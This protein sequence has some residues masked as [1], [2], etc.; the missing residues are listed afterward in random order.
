MLAQATSTETWVNAA[1][2][3]HVTNLDHFA[4]ASNATVYK[5][6]AAQLIRET[7]GIEPRDLTFVIH[8]ARYGDDGTIAKQNWYIYHSGLWTDA[9]FSSQRRI[10]GRKQIWLL[11][12]QF[13]ARPNSNTTYV[14]ETKKKSAAAFDH[15][16]QVMSLFGVNLTP[17]VAQPR[18]VWNAKLLDIPYVPSDVLINGVAFDNEGLSWIDFSAAVPAKQTAAYGAVDLYVRPAD[19]KGLGF[20]TWPH[21]VEGVRVGNR[22]LKSILLGAGWGP[23]Y[24]GVVMGNGTRSLSYGVN[25][26]TS[27][28]TS[29]VKK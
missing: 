27:A 22:P 10:Y 2:P 29:S 11:Y 5:S 25:I 12:L 15:A 26:S 18:N 20:G 13:N 23:F 9:Q 24:A 21:F 19:I 17:A 16:Q 3:L 4:D 14:I 6:G 7:I 8:V 1:R 28:I